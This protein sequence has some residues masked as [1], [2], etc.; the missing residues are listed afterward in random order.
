MI[1]LNLQLYGSSL[2]VLAYLQGMCIAN[3]RIIS[4]KYQQDLEIDLLYTFYDVQ[5]EG[6]VGMLT[7]KIC[8]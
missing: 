8:F 6:I 1:L 5:I 7:G 3:H 2:T 4:R